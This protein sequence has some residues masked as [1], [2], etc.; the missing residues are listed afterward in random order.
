MD[1]IRTCQICDLVATVWMGSYCLNNLLWHSHTVSVA[2][3]VICWCVAIWLWGLSWRIPHSCTAIERPMARNR[4]CT[5]PRWCRTSSPWRRGS[6]FHWRGGRWWSRS[7]TSH[8]FWRSSCSKCQITIPTRF[9]RRSRP[10][11]W[12]VRNPTRPLRFLPHRICIVDCVGCRRVPACRK[13]CHMTAVSSIFAGS[14]PRARGSNSSPSS[15]STAWSSCTFPRCCTT[16]TRPG[17]WR[18]AVRPREAVSVAMSGALFCVCAIHST[19]Y[20]WKCYYYSE[21]GP[22]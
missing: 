2:P 15:L 21:C 12:G 3:P 16:A 10:S 20:L 5:P 22:Y 9:A 1:S 17:S 11:H 7:T 8:Y 4:L 13:L 14:R 18:G 19:Y 6:T